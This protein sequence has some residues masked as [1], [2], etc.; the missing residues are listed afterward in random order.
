MTLEEVLD[1]LDI[2]DAGRSI[3]EQ[4]G[5]PQ[6][7]RAAVG[8][9]QTEADRLATIRRFYPD[10]QPFGDD[11]FVFTDPRTGRRA[12]YNPPGLDLGDPISV[13]PEIAELVGGT[14]GTVLA[15]RL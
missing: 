7:V 8:G 11:N 1:T 12:L 14:V 4:T 5:A 15:T 13:V 10:A 2:L 9:A 3:D 6:N